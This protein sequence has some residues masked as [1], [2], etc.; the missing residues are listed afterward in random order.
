MVNPKKSGPAKRNLGG[1]PRKPDAAKMTAI[2]HI[3]VTD[4]M[5][6]RLQLEAERRG[7]T[8]AGMVR[9]AFLAA[10]LFADN[11]VAVTKAVL[12][13]PGATRTRVARRSDKRVLREPDTMT[14]PMAGAVKKMQPKR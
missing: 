3:P 10:D 2:L 1:R 4:D 5:Y 8:L 12:R 11:P 6:A 7:D 9:R 13:D 14:M